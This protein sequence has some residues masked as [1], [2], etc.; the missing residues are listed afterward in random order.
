[1]EK[2]MVFSTTDGSTTLK[3]NMSDNEITGW[4]FESTIPNNKKPTMY[5]FFDDNNLLTPIQYMVQTGIACA[6]SLKETLKTNSEMA[7]SWLEGDGC[8]NIVLLD[9]MFK[10]PEEVQLDLASKG[11]KSFI[12]KDKIS[13]SSQ[14]KEITTALVTEILDKENPR[15]EKIF[16][17]YP[18]LSIIIDVSKNKSW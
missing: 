11:I 6:T 3:I 18:K 5:V 1:M 7:K 14:R 4:D 15:I 2:E 8:K 13:K 16:E 9:T 10:T 17:N 12:I